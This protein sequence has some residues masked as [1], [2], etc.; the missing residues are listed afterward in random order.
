MKNITLR[1]LLLSI[2]IATATASML[3]AQSKAMQDMPGMSS[4]ASAQVDHAMS[5]RHMDMG[6]HMKMTA[7]RS[8]QPG[9][10]EKAQQ[11]AAAARKVSEKYR[12]YRMALA[13]G[14]HIFMPKVPQ[15]QYHFN[16]PD[17]AREAVDHL[18][19]NHPTSLLYEK[20]G[21]SYKLIGV[22]YTA[23]KWANEDDLNERIPLSIAQWHAHVNL[24]LPPPD[25]T[26]AARDSSRF[27]VEGSISTQAECEAVG[28]RFVSQIFGWMVHVYPFATN[29]NDIWS[30]ERQMGDE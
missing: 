30:V 10:Q 3:C 23:P 14:F 28:G 2:T 19:P 6:P 27:G 26:Q 24:C 16:N 11:V 7:L 17:Y 22:M 8:Q 12:D 4:A 29:P 15:K 9:D 20:N 25:R 5:G 1:Y 18:N 13:D 21:D